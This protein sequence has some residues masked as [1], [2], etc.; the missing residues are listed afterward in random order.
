MAKQ[1]KTV[2]QPSYHRTGVAAADIAK[3]LILKYGTDAGEVAASAAV[4]DAFA[5]VTSEKMFSGKSQSYQSEGIA[6]VLSAGA[7][8]AHALV[9]SSASGKAAAAATGNL[10]LGRA[11]TAAGGA[12]ELIEVELWKGRFVAP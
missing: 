7:I 12:D 4:S 3:N 6:Q 9:T 1:P 10:V 2:T 8:S 11:M 5:G